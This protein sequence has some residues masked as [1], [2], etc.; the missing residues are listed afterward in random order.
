M[1]KVKRHTKRVIVAIAGTVVLAI[2]IVAIPYPGPGWLIVFAGLALLATEFEWAQRLLH[3]ARH[4]YD[5]WQHWLAAQPMTVKQLVLVCTGVVVIAT[6]W[7][8][9]TFG[10]ADTL[11]H[12][13]QHWLHSPV[14]I[15]IL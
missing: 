7:L 14:G 4:E 5:R 11:L 12:L 10:L 6:L 1:E 13:H 15:H 9:D 2:G 8:L 3:K